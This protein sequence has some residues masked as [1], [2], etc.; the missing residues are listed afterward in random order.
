MR[1]EL[2]LDLV[3]ALAHDLRVVRRRRA[4]S[5]PGDAVQAAAR[6]RRGPASLLVA[7]G[8][9]VAAGAELHLGR[10][11]RAPGSGRR[12]AA[13]L[14]ATRQSAL[15][16]DRA[17]CVVEARDLLD[18]DEEAVG[19]RRSATETTSGALKP[20]FC[21]RVADLA[22]VDRLGER[23]LDLGAALEVG[24]EFGPG[25]DE[26]DDREDEQREAEADQVP[27]HRH[28]VVDCGRA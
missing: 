28:E 8:D 20:T 11:A 12:G 3:V 16:R 19:V 14:S 27:A 13:P 9:L 25:T 18:A 7:R 24:A 15:R 10:R 5:T 2:D 21:D 17:F 23:D 4:S 22:A 6:P 1:L 26:R